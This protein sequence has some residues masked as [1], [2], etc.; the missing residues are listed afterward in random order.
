MDPLQQRF[1][2]DPK[3]VVIVRAAE[4]ALVGVQPSPAQAIAAREALGQDIAPI[5][6]IRSSREYRLAVAGNVLGQF[7]RQVGHGF[8]SPTGSVAS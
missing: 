1:Q 4:A 8:G 5:D 7:L 2:P 3:D 6:D